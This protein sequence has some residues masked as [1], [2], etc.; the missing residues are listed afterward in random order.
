MAFPRLLPNTRMPDPVPILI[1]G[2][3]P[4]V[5]DSQRQHRQALI[6][7]G[8][9]SVLVDDAH[10]I[11]HLSEKAGSYLVHPAGAPTLDI[12]ALVRAEL[13]PELRA[14]LNRAFQ[15][16]ESSMSLP[17]P[18]QF[19][20]HSRYVCLQVSPI[21]T[22]ANP[23]R[24]LVLFIE[25][26][27]AQMTG[28]GRGTEDAEADSDIQQL[29]GN[30]SRRAPISRPAVSNSRTRAKASRR[31]MRNSNPSM[32]NTVRLRRNWRPRAKSCNP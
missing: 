21:G 2:E 12:S 5:A 10:R 18:V 4:R 22:S 27:P 19:N 26:G 9:P 3:H 1:G 14:L 11:L 8:S 7:L 15:L 16:G 25:G 23:S 31:Q 13:V 28:A 32:R 17:I 6:E 20:G 30:W 29:R 24:A